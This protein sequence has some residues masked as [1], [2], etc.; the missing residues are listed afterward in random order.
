MIGGGLTFLARLEPGAPEFQALLNLVKDALRA[1][2]NEAGAKRRIAAARARRAH[3]DDKLFKFAMGLG[4]AVLTGQ[5]VLNRGRMPQTVRILLSADA[6]RKG[7]VPVPGGILQRAERPHA[8]F[9]GSR[10][11]VGNILS[12]ARFLVQPVWTRSGR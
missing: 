7:N 8:L 12:V 4:A 3:E 6:R 5:N 11:G 10:P 9:Q 1:S 2:D